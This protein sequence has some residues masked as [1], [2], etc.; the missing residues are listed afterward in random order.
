MNKRKIMLIIL[1]LLVTAVIV[2]VVY[3]NIRASQL[4]EMYPE[5][6]KGRSFHGEILFDGDKSITVPLS[7]RDYI[8]ILSSAELKNGQSFSAPP[9]PS[10]SISLR[11]DKKNFGIYAAQDGSICV[12]DAADPDNTWKFFSDKGELF[13]ALYKKHLSA[14]GEALPEA[15]G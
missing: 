15:I 14:G 4:G 8:K 12:F 1:V 3:D 2:T 9:S 10:F 13:E 11:C 7:D 5:L 6:L